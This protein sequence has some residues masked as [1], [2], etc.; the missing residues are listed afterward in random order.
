MSELHSSDSVRGRSTAA[1]LLRKVLATGWFA[2][3]ALARAL[4]IS[5]AWLEAYVNESKPMPL[6]RQLCLA[7]FVIEC[8]PPLARA[9]HR[10]RSQVAAA[11]A[12]HS[13]VTETHAQS[14]PLRRF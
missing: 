7:L 13:G 3:E 1:Q 2:P 14:P 11:M 10:L 12:F 8:I 9:G 6:D 4:V 5:D